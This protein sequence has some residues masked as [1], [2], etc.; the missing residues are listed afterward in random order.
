MP[1]DG[2][3]DASGALIRYCPE[4]EAQADAREVSRLGLTL[5]GHTPGTSMLDAGIRR[6]RR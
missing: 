4:R 3:N 1:C 6:S 2:L 5:A